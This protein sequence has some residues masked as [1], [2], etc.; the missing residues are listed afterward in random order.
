MKLNPSTRTTEPHSRRQFLKVSAAAAASLAFTGAS[1]ADDA[2][3]PQDGSESETAAYRPDYKATGVKL[4]TD[5]TPLADGFFMPGEEMKHEATVMVFPQEQ[6]WEDEGIGRVRK[7]WVGT[8]HA[9]AGH[10]P[11]RMVVHPRDAKAARKA[12][13]KDIEL[14]ELRVNDGWARDTV[15]LFLVNGKGERRATGFVFNG[16]GAKFPPLSADALL[17][18]RL[19]AK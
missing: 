9:I 2:P 6:N 3:D 14:I 5:S 13:S 10:E 1:R 17:K 18:A 15:P 11:V 8:A 4:I 12:L 19:C 7:E 16:W